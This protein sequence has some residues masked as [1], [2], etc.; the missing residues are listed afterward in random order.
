MLVNDPEAIVVH[1][2]NERL[3]QLAQRLERRKARGGVICWLELLGKRG[4]AALSTKGLL[5]EARHSDRGVALDG[6]AFRKMKALGDY[7]LLWRLQR[8]TVRSGCAVEDRRGSAHIGGRGP[9]PRRKRWTRRRM[10]A[11]FGYKLRHWA[12][13]HQR[14]PHR[15]AQKV[16]R[17]GLLAKADLGLRGMHIHIDFRIGHLDEQQHHREY[18]GRQDVAIGV[19]QSMLDQAV[20]DQPAIHERVDR[21][22]VQLLDFRLGNKSVYA[23]TPWIYRGTGVAPVFRIVFFYTSPRRRL[24]KA[25]ARERQ[26]RSYGNEL[27]ENI[28]SKHLINAFAVASHG[29]C[30]QHSVGRRMQF[31]MLVGMRQRIMRDQRSN[32]RK[33]GGLC[34][35]KLFA[36]RNIKEEIADGDGR[37]GGKAGLFDAKNLSACNFDHRTR[38]LVRGAGL[39]S[40]AADRCNRRQSFSAK[41]ES[42]DVQQ[43]FCILDLRSRMPLEGQ[44]GIIAHHATAIVGDLDEFLAPR[45]A[46]NCDSH[47]TGV[48]GILQQLLHDRC[49][50]L[51]N[52]ASSNLVGNVLGK[53][54]NAAHGNVKSVSQRRGREGKDAQ[55]PLRL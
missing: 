16:M 20:A 42:R 10:G 29:W 6:D 15:I 25:D 34:L 22:P 47:R 51:D 39:Q 54:V 28:L 43:V 33:L 1:R 45:F 40:Q 7:W 24:W 3:T 11:N 17:H 41:A 36:R 30:N 55:A 50:T 52:F 4:G 49:R 53:D 46:L 19:R 23:Q 13:L 21:I 5:R 26:F 12:R 44:Q 9:C 38:V 48:E 31:K 32:V 27:I 14:R 2:Q 8:K 37:S 35:Q 18:R